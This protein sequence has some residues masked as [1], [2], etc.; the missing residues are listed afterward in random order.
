MTEELTPEE[1]QQKV[2]AFAIEA[3]G[4][5]LRSRNILEDASPQTLDDPALLL[6]LVNTVTDDLEDPKKCLTVACCFVVAMIERAKR[7]R[8]LLR[9]EKGGAHE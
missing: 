5:W 6:R 9:H 2:Q 7:E 3:H 4:A 1:L 8:G